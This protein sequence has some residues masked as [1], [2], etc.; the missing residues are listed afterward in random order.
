MTLRSTAGSGAGLRR[1]QRF[2]FTAEIAEIA[3]KN[4]KESEIKN[5]DKG[6]F[7]LSVLLNP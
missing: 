1:F 2:V 5:T 7:P 3:E 4:S 6:G